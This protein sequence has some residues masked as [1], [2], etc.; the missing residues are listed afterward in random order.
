LATQTGGPGAGILHYGRK[1]WL[2]IITTIL[3]I[4][5]IVLATG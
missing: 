1:P 4:L 2:I 3:I 5:N